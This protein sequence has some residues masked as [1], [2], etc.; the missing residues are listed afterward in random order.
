MYEHTKPIHPYL[1][2]GFGIS[3]RDSRESKCTSEALKW[4]RRPL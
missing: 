3:G 4:Q 1:D 2:V